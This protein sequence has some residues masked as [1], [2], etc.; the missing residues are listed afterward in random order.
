MKELLDTAYEGIAE[1]NNEI[2][3]MKK[4]EE[5]KEITDQE[6]MISRELDNLLK[7]LDFDKLGSTYTETIESIGKC[8]IS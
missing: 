3:E 1:N 6:R 5:A 2:Q 4:E 8:S 7:Q